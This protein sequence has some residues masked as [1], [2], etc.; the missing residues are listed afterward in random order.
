MRVP[1]LLLDLRD[2][3]VDLGVQQW[4]LRSLLVLGGGLSVAAASAAGAGAPWVQSA[5]LLAFAGWAAARPDSSRPALLVAALLGMW[6][7]QVDDGT[8]WSLPAAVGVL[9][10]HTSAAYAAETPPGGRTTAATHRRWLVHSALVLSLTGT[11]WAATWLLEAVRAEGSAL[12]TGAALTGV[13]V[14]TVALMRHRVR[15]GT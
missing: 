13:A 5:A 8:I 11:G 15:S 7:L 6:L 1:F 12:V 10:V 3:A 14:M 2:N 4:V 9:V